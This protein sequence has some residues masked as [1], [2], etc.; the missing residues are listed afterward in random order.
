MRKRAFI[1]LLM[2]AGLLAHPLLFA[3]DDWV[4]ADQVMASVNHV[5][6]TR[7]QVVQEARIVL[8]EKKRD[9]SE[10]LSVELLESVLER[11]IAKELIYQ[12][13]ERVGQQNGE[14]SPIEGDAL[15]AAFGRHFGTPREYDVFV[16]SIGLS[17]RSFVALLIRNARI[18]AFIDRRMAL[19]SRVSDEEVRRAANRRPSERESRE[20]AEAR[21]ERIAFVRQDLEREKYSRSFARWMEDLQGRNSVH[22]LAHFSRSVPALVVDY[23]D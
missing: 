8:A 9:W 17:R 3:G 4:L 10:R 16:E 12:E 19:M 23:G 7:N 5:A 15:V 11:M 21:A 2:L 1:F 14:E 13:L 22:R 6:I 18:E 20:S